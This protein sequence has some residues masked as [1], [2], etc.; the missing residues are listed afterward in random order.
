MQILRRPEA[1]PPKSALC[2]GA[3]DGLHRGHRALLQ[4]ARDGGDSLA[5]L[6]FDPHPAAVLAPD[7]A[8]PRLQSCEQRSRIAEAL[9]VDTL[10]ELPFDNDVAALEAAGIAPLA[11]VTLVHDGE[12]STATV[13][14]DPWG[15]R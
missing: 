9:G 11:L 14:G 15:V 7:R 6:T 2:I 5:I 10:A 1:L 12:T 3:F 13:V 4:R 8:P